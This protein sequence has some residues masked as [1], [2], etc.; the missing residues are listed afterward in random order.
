MERPSHVPEDAI[1]LGDDHWWNPETLPSGAAGARVHFWYT[2]SED[3]ETEES[4]WVVAIVHIAGTS[5]VDDGAAWSIATTNCSATEWLNWKGEPMPITV[6]LAFHAAA[7][8]GW[9]DHVAPTILH[10]DSI[11][12]MTKLRLTA[13]WAEAKEA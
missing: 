12:A 10:C 9:L 2:W 4:D 5:G 7:T 8:K 11:D 1:S 13:R 6:Q 3:M